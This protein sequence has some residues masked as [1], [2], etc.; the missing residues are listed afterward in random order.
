M[1]RSKCFLESKSGL[2]CASCHNPHDVPR[3]AEATR[4]YDAAC[5][6]C[7]ATDFNRAVA[8]GKHTSVA[9]CADCH[10][11]KRRTDDGRTAVATD[12]L[13]QRRK[14]EASAAESRNAMRPAMPTAARRAHDLEIAAVAGEQPLLAPAQVVDKSI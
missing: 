5:R 12:H 11:P 14:P 6:K 2:Q 9:G 1:R 8:S 10:M 3:G 13:I 7:H 4:H